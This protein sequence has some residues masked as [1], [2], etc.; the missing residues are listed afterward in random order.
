MKT[1]DKLFDGSVDVVGDIHGHI[2]ALDNLLKH[3]GYRDDG[4][5]PDGRRL[6][7][8]GDL[9]DRGPDSPGVVEWVASL[10]KDGNARCV[11]G[12][13]E[14]NILRNERK[15]G[16]EWF[17]DDPDRHNDA[18]KPATDRQ[19]DDIQA[20]LSTLPLAL[21]RNDLRVVHAC[22]HDDSI[23]TL[24]SDGAAHANAGKA[25]DCYE[26]AVDDRLRTSDDWARY[27]REKED[28]GDLV[29]YNDNQPESHWPEA[30][31]LPGYAAVEEARQMENPVAVLTS[32]EERATKEVYP[33]AGRWRF[34]ERV[35]WWQRYEDER[36]VV[37]GHYWRTLKANGAAPARP[38]KLDLFSEAEP[39]EWLGPRGNVYCVDFSVAGRAK[40]HA[41]D[42]CRL[43]AVRWPEKQVI[44]DNGEEMPTG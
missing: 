10:V 22:W 15:F 3:M 17:F 32:G 8:V 6:V 38:G 19:R 16:N 4:L 13:H 24:A 5:H 7:F 34:V 21:E 1:V 14:L 2:D 44:F 36:A 39:H 25:F 28:L 26:Q 20:F 18:E 40:G 37:M 9:V 27:L 29:H 41:E 31:L 23:A 35:P 33:I 11:L 12:N 43:G 42:V 30:R